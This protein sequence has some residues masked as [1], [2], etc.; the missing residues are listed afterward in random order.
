MALEIYKR[1]QGKNTRLG[2]GFA[3]G[4]ISAFGCYRLFLKLSSTVDNLVV[5]MLVPVF[6]FGVMAAVLFWL[7]NK[8]S[9]ADFMISAEGEMKKVNWSTRE[10]IVA[11]TIVVI[12]VL[13]FMAVLLGATD[14]LFRTLFSWLLESG[15]VT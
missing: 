12:V 10:E 15:Q 4:T 13:L 9:F 3:L 11:S 8:P 5:Q 7:A 2:S 6:V 14:L 1:G